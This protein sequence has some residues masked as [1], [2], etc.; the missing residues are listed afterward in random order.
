MSRK[1]LGLKGT[2]NLHDF[3]DQITIIVKPG[4]NNYIVSGQY[5]CKMQ[6]TDCRLG[7]ICR[8]GTKCRLQTGF[9]M[10]TKA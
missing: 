9:K 2:V 3:R 8:L 7:L 10:Q 6:T 1:L 4:F 5:T